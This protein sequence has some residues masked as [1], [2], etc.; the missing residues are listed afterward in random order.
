MFWTC[1]VS[2]IVDIVREK[3]GS[4]EKLSNDFKM[5]KSVYDT[6]ESDDVEGERDEAEEK[7][8]IT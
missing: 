6:I 1:S 5:A 8:T 4:V 2:F 7:E 3:E